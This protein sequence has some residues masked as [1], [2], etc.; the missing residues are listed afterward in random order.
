MDWFLY[1][2]GL[3]HE[4]VKVKVLKTFK[5]S[6][7]CPIKTYQSFKRRVILKIPS[8]SFQRT[9]ALSDAFKMKPLSFLCVQTKINSNFAE[10]SNRLF[11]LS[12]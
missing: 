9:Y 5:I 7:D 4:R 1:D 6:S 3:R 12:L 11:L 8:I 10:R 2:N